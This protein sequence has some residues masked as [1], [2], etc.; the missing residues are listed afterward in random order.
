MGDATGWKWATGE[1]KN[2]TGEKMGCTTMLHAESGLTVEIRHESAHGVLFKHKGEGILRCDRFD[3]SVLKRPSFLA[4]A[5][6]DAL[7]AGGGT[8]L[9]TGTKMEAGEWKQGLNAATKTL[10]LS[11]VYKDGAKIQF[12]LTSSGECLWYSF[13]DKVLHISSKVE[14]GSR[15]V[16]RLEANKLLPR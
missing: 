15:V 7:Q 9:A 2:K 14:G 11:F 1:G 13:Q 6:D 10:M 3:G 12:Y 16:P 5:L 4:P 8:D